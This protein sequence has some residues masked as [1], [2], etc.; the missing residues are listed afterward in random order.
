L[1]EA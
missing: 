1:R